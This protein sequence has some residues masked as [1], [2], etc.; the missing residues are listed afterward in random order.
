MTFMDSPNDPAQSYFECER[1][2]QPI[3]EKIE[4]AITGSL[5][6]PT[7]QQKDFFAQVETDYPRLVAKFIPIIEAEFGAWMPLPVIKDFNAEFK[8]T[9]LDIPACSQRPIEWEIVFDT[10]H[11]VNHIVTVGMMDDEPQYVR[12]DG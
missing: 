1:Y 9:L 11:D 3:G 2:F 12:I 5:S 6:G 7:Q 10:V 8:P 4:L